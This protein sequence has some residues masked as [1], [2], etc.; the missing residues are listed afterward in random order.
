MTVRRSK[1]A[2]KALTN[3]RHPKTR[4]E[5]RGGYLRHLEV[6]ASMPSSQGPVAVAIR[7]LVADTRRV[8]RLVAAIEAALPPTGTVEGQQNACAMLDEVGRALAAWKAGR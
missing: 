6:F 3:P 1:K 8:D 4:A 7:Q 5:R 2:G